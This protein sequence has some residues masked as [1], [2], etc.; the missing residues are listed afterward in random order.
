MELLRSFD[1]GFCGSDLVTILWSTSSASDGLTLCPTEEG[2]L[3]SCLNRGIFDGG[4][5]F[6]S[7][8]STAVCMDFID[9]A[10]LDR[11]DPG[12]QSEVPGAANAGMP[13][14]LNTG[15]EKQFA[16]KFETFSIRSKFLGTNKG[17]VYDSVH[18]YRKFR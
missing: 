9:A 4:C 6:A 3:D 8:N 13:A 16:L 17:F 10:E 2:I 14:S 1:F 5:G 12:R 11:C 18:F 7:A 15:L